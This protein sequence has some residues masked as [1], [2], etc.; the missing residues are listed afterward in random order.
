MLLPICC[1]SIEI[2][3]RSN[4]IYL[5]SSIT[6]ISKKAI[7]VISNKIISDHWKEYIIPKYSIQ[8]MKYSLQMLL[9]FCLIIL[10]FLI[11][12]Y[13]LSGFIQYTISLNGI[14][15]SLLFAFGYAYFR[16]LIAK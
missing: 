12:D 3:I 10:I 1:L 11:V 4:Y 2:I 7:K 9:I 8:L 6:K 14:I 16:K 15:E 13:F 5:L